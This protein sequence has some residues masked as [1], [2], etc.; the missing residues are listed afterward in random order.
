MQIYTYNARN[1]NMSLFCS[2]DWDFLSV[3]INI[4]LPVPQNKSVE[5]LQHWIFFFNS[6]NQI[7]FTDVITVHIYIYFKCYLANRFS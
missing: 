1:A 3:I 2:E 5:E 4:N 6:H 7:F